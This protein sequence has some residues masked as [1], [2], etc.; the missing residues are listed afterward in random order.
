VCTPAREFGPAV[1][2]RPPRGRPDDVDG[3]P[4]HLLPG[5]SN[6]GV[7]PGRPGG[8]AGGEAPATRGEAEQKGKSETGPRFSRTSPAPSLVD[9]V[10]AYSNRLDLLDELVTALQQLQRAVQA[11]QQAPPQR[12]SVQSTASDSQPRRVGDRLGTAA[13]SQLVTDFAGGMPKRVLAE[14]YGV[15]ESS[16]KRLLRQHRTEAATS[17]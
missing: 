7:R 5:Y 16:I 8:G 15:S 9:L 3:R 14:R 17:A 1:P 13:V 10:R 11:E 4:V 6:P 2:P 12:I